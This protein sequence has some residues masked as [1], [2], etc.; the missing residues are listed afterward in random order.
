[1]GYVVELAKSGRAACRTCKSKIEKDDV[2]VGAQK[3]MGDYDTTFWYHLMCF[4][5]PKTLSSAEELAGFQQ[6]SADV[7]KQ[8]ESKFAGGAAATPT[9][10]KSNRNGGKRVKEV[11][12]DDAKTNRKGGK[13][14]KPDSDEEETRTAPKPPKKKGRKAKDESEEDKSVEDEEEKTAK[15]SAKKR[16]PAAKAKA[17]VDPAVELERKKV[18]A[19]REEFQPMSVTQLKEYLKLNDMTTSG[20]KQELIDRLAD[21]KTFGA[22]PR[23]P[24]CFGGRLRVTYDKPYGHGGQGRWSCPGFHDDEQF[25]VCSFRSD[26]VIARPAWKEP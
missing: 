24:S 21:A 3:S 12:D 26:E 23:C 2:R 19:A 14:R 17:R 13:R 22:L 20:V 7:Q 8:V 15:K 4:K 9:D 18:E 25:R 1:M 11:S 16:R 5:V 6:L 10:T